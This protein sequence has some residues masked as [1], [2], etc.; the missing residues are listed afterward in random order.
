MITIVSQ[1]RCVIGDIDE[2]DFNLFAEFMA[3]AKG[4]VL[5]ECCSYGGVDGVGIAIAE[6]I[7]ASNKNTTINVYGVANS[8]ATVIV[9]SCKHRTATKYSAFQFHESSDTYPETYS[10]SE[11]LQLAHNEEQKEIDYC[12]M[13]AMFTKRD[14]SFWRNLIK[15]K[16]QYLSA[17][18]AL[19]YGL[20]D[21]II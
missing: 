7:R 8:I 11:L 18:Q 1:N 9:A 21:E 4:K 2:D 10:T 16:E 17:R 6:Y 5:I 12:N 13:L 15:N 14:A 19:E 20:I 3:K